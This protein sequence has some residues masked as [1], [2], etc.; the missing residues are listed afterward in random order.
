MWQMTVE[1]HDM[2]GGGDVMRTRQ[3][4]QREARRLINWAL[5]VVAALLVFSILVEGIPISEIPDRSAM[6]AADIQAISS[7]L[8]AL[9]WPAVAAFV[10]WTFRDPVQGVLSRSKQLTVKFFGQ[11]VMVQADSQGQEIAQLLREVQDTVLDL[12][13]E[14]RKVFLDIKSAD[15]RRTVSDY[16]PGFARDSKNHLLLQE[17]RDRKLIRPLEGGSWQAEKHPVVTKFARLV[18]GVYPASLIA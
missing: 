11:E 13:E 14:H 8:T 5:G 2:V 12:S 9:A 17:L 18:L 15:G 4:R 3:E 10:L 7:L 6:S 16:F 1:A